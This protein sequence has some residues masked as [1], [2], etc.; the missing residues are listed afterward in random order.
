MTRCPSSSRYVFLLNQRLLATRVTRNGLPGYTDNASATPRTQTS[1]SVDVIAPFYVSSTIAESS[2]C[3]V[4]VRVRPCQICG[5]GLQWSGSDRTSEKARWRWDQLCIHSLR[6]PSFGLGALCFP[7][8]LG[9]TTDTSISSQ[10]NLPRHLCESVT[11]GDYPC[12]CL[13]HSRRSMGS[14]PS[15]LIK[16]AAMINLGWPTYRRRSVSLDVHYTVSSPGSFVADILG[17]WSFEP[18]HSLPPVEALRALDLP[19]LIHV[20]IVTQLPLD[21]P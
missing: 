10:E 6:D 7:V 1:P 14:L 21:N 4:W 8:T 18:A 19:H 2:R 5:V 12:N 13:C 11:R 20:Q 3:P 9:P 16:I 17:C 15:G